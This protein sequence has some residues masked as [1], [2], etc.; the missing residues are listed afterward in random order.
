M[1]LSGQP[2]SSTRRPSP[3]GN[4]N[5]GGLRDAP[6]QRTLLS[7]SRHSFNQSS[8]FNLSRKRVRAIF[9]PPACTFTKATAK[10]SAYIAVAFDGNDGTFGSTTNSTIEGLPHLMES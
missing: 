7:S 9:P 1:D 2:N 3:N 5:A 10:C 6:V 8:S 4:P